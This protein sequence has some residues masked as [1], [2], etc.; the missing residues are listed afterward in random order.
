MKNI[1]KA[2]PIFPISTAAKILGISVHTLRMYE[3]E[4]FIIPYKKESNQRAYSQNDID[5]IRCIR[6]A[7]NEHKISI[8]GIKATYSLIPCWE[9]K[10][11]PEEGR[12]K[13]AAY[14]NYLEPCWMYKHKNNFC[15]IENCRDCEV[16][17]DF[18][19]CGSIKE[20]L[21]QMHRKSQ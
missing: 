10:N 13:C 17:N 19:E 8:N 7:I 6:Q 5:R 15:T 2:E 14:T 11:C 12:E 16:Y 20:L 3:R 1:S 4:G 18:S 9:I 21:K